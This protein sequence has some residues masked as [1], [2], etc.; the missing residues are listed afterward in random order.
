MS[1]PPPDDLSD[2]E[3]PWP[4]VVA[5]S[6]GAPA[7]ASFVAAPTQRPTRRL[8]Q[9]HLFGILTLGLLVASGIL[10]LV[11]FLL[12]PPAPR[13]CPK[14]FTCGGPVA[15]GAV[16]NGTIYKSR[17][18][19]F[20]VEYGQNSGTQTSPAGIIT[21]YDADDQYQQ[22][23][24]EIVGL[25]ADGTTAS[26]VVSSVAQQIA[27]SAIEEYAVPN[28]YVGDVPAVGEAY[29]VEQNGS[30]NSSGLE[31]LIVLAAVHG[32]LAVVVVDMGPYWRFS[33]SNTTEMNLNDHPSP[34]D[35]FAALF[36]DPEVNSVVWPSSS[37]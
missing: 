26:E 21:A 15:R 17:E 27:P 12:L 25:P 8:R 14:L 35:Q 10:V 22:G 19:G 36:A 18:F 32:N 9:H 33:S 30:S 37:G 34:A 2:P 6:P 28:P 4:T 3:S 5:G 23:Q 20:S 31:R 29:D 16:H 11:V 7:R 1:P 24:V 13:H